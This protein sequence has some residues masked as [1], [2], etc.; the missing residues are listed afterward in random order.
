M[1]VCVRVCV[2]VDDYSGGWV[3]KV[4]VKEQCYVRPPSY[5]GNS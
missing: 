1:Y 5:P 4:S 2:C 3:I